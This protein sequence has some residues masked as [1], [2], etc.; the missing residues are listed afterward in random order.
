M[1]KNKVAEIKLVSELAHPE[2]NHVERLRRDVGSFQHNVSESNHEI[3]LHRQVL[4]GKLFRHD[5]ATTL[6]L[7][8]EIL[9]D[10][11]RDDG[12][13][14]LPGSCVRVKNPT[15]ERSSSSSKL[16]KQQVASSISSRLRT[17]WYHDYALSPQPSW[18]HNKRNA[19]SGLE[20]QE[21]TSKHDGFKVEAGLSS[22]NVPRFTVVPQ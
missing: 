19:T 6:I 20:I 8:Q 15:T 22:T 10:Q 13:D 16:P 14:V 3:L 9:G 1:A 11:R 4:Q 2:Q 18:L 17:Y 7:A 21:N 12:G 5:R